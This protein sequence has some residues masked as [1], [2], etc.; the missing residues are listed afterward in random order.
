MLDMCSLKRYAGV[1][2]KDMS[3][4]RQVSTILPFLQL[5]F[6]ICQVLNRPCI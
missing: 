2:L 5:A 6:H 1:D 3:N 4:L